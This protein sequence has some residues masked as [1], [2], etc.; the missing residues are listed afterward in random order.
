MYGRYHPGGTWKTAGT[1]RSGAS[2]RGAWMGKRNVFVTRK[3]SKVSQMSG[4]K[5]SPEP[6]NKEKKT[7]GEESTPAAR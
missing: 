2:Q 7:K 4:C 6:A 5:R 3:R 1:R